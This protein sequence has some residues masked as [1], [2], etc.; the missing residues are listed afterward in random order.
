MH[1]YSVNCPSTTAENS[2]NE[3]SQTLSYQ[4]TDTADT[5]YS[6]VTDGRPVR[7]TCFNGQLFENIKPPSR[8]DFLDLGGPPT[9]VNNRKQR[10]HFSGSVTIPKNMWAMI[11]IMHYVF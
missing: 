8:P 10:L 5:T 6:V 1:P 9:P 2:D 11:L 3:L 7:P 4:S